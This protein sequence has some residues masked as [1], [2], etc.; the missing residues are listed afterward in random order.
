MRRLK[1]DYP[2]CVLLLPANE[3]T[4]T[5]SS[6]MM[7]EM[8]YRVAATTTRTYWLI[9]RSLTPANLVVL[10]QSLAYWTAVA[11][12]RNNMPIETWSIASSKRMTFLIVTLY[13]DLSDC[14]MNSF[15]ALTFSL[16][17]LVALFVIATTIAVSSSL[18]LSLN[19]YLSLQKKIS[20]MI[21][22]T[23]SVEMMNLIKS[24]NRSM[25]WCKMLM[26]FTLFLKY[27]FLSWSNNAW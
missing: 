15:M 23:M 27:S 7:S 19:N 3:I 16:D 17:L 20:P 24:A 21:V 14:L 22:S 1:K 8:F 26:R 25:C 12:C 13:V 4:Q 2:W 9:I 18:S 6:S 10:V 5:D 11:V